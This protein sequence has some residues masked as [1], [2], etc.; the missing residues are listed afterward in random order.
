MRVHE[1][2]GLRFDPIATEVIKHEL[3]AISEEMAIAVSRTA[4]SVMV[5]S[6]DFAASV[7]DDEGRLIGQGYA[8][9]IQL[10][11]FDAVVA[12]LR[13]RF[14]TSFQPGDVFVTN[15]PY[16]GVGH[17]PDVFVIIPVF[18]DDRLIGFTHAYS[19]HTDI[20]GRFPGGMSSWARSSFEE[21]IR[22]PPVRLYTA[23]VRNDA[24]VE[25]IVANVRDVVTWI[26]DLE[27]KVAGCRRGGEQLIRLVESRGF[28]AYRS[29]CDYLCMRS[30]ET[31]RATIDALPDGIYR[32]A[33]DFEDDGLGTPDARLRIALV[34]EIEGDAIRADFSGSAGQ[35]DSAI[36]LP[37]TMTKSAVYTALKVLVEPDTLMNA[38]FISAVDVVAPRGSIVNPVHPAPVSGRAPLAFFVLDLVLRALAQAAPQRVPVP[39]EGGDLMHYASENGQRVAL[40]TF[41]GGWGAR[42]NCDGIDGVAPLAFGAYGTSSVEI[43]ERET[44]VIVDTFEFVADTEGAG[45]HRGSL[46]VRR[47]WRFPD[48]GDAMVR[49]GR[50][51]PSEGLGGGQAGANAGTQVCIGGEES[52]LPRQTHVHVAVSRG[53]RI[54]HQVAGTGGF[55][56]PRHRSPN[57]VLGDVLDGKVTVARAKSVYGVVVDV[58][59]R[60]VD[61]EATTALRTVANPNG[62]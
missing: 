18:L 56:D 58:A 13:G 42:T 10:A 33:D 62:D 34:L 7:S 49:R 53:D 39:G 55:G 19:H 4:R 38:G 6:G 61:S 30:A 23:G 24:L 60:C 12:S 36:N 5:K 46:A 57:L 16:A 48:R 11:H 35:V 54:T 27:A 47:S 20:G 43:L 14:G 45:E 52:A 32:A 41:F 17:L 40:D 3:A 21:G 59:N 31:M 28:E 25:T 26:G 22:I 1:P 37:F 2:P 51:K 9:P 44:G 8:A 15:D 50:L 29:C